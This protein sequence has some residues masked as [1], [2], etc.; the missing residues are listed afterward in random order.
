MTFSTERVLA[1]LNNNFPF[2][3]LDES[4]LQSMS[5]RMGSLRL[6]AGTVIYRRG[7]I[8][9]HLYL[10]LCGRVKMEASP[11]TGHP[12]AWELSKGDVFGLEVRKSNIYR[13]TDAVCETEV[14][15]LRI[16]RPTLDEL[17]SIYYD[18]QKGLDLYLHTFLLRLKLP[19]PWLGEDERVSLITRRHPFFLILRILL[20]GTASFVAFGVIL[21]LAFTASGFSIGIFI[22]ALAVLLLGMG[23]TAWAAVEWSNDYFFI[24]RERVLVQ[25]KLIGFFESRQESPFSAILS[26]GLETSFVGRAVG[27]GAITLRSYTGNLRFINLPTADLI[28]ELL[29]SQRFKIDREAR[30]ENQNEMQDVLERRFGMREDR[31]PSRPESHPAPAKGTMYQS[32]SLLDLAARFFGLRQ[33]NDDGVVY[34]THWWILLKKT[35][36][37]GLVLLGVIILVTVK[38]IGLLPEATD[39]AVYSIALVLTVAAWIWWLYQY[40]DWHNDI[41]I[42]TTDQLVDVNRKPLGSEERRSAPIKNI[43]TV[44]FKRKG[45]IGLVLNFGTVRIQIGNEELTFDNVYDP[46]AI[47]SEIFAYFKYRNEKIKRQEQEKLADWIEAYDQL[48]GKENERTRPIHREKSE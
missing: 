6:P 2:N 30:H 33:Q 5:A 34:R 35:M 29:E 28:Y 14:E 4:D 12:A 7:D 11:K 27:Y 47:Q 10:V 45:I 36:L 15:L 17:C 24:T 18:L 41:Y 46:A 3:L 1:F 31:I 32:G 23:L 26:T 8:P 38:W 21:S 25:K 16:D 40:T 42:I 39:A 22:L 20:I 44:E 13:L 43:Q 48:K 37:P 9:D 19:L